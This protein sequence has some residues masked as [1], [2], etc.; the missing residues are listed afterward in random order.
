M[1]Q[2]WQKLAQQTTEIKGDVGP[3]LQIHRQTKA[4]DGISYY[5]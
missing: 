2:E 5:V 1:A 4:I 3:K